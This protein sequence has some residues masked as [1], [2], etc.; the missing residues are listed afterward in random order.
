MLWRTAFSPSRLLTFSPSHLSTING[1]TQCVFM[2]YVDSLFNLND[3]H[4]GILICQILTRFKCGLSSR[5][6]TRVSA[7][8]YAH[9]HVP[10]QCFTFQESGQHLIDNWAIFSQI[11]AHVVIERET[12]LMYTY[13]AVVWVNGWPDFVNIYLGMPLRRRHNTL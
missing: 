5:K 11:V 1:N 12:P 8:M 10:I 7:R 2:S 4:I 3:C 13:I 9:I 6:H